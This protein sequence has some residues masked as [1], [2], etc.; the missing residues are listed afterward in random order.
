MNQQDSDYFKELSMLVGENYNKEVSTAK[1]RLWWQLLKDYPIGDIEQAIFNHMKESPFMPTPA[2][3]IKRMEPDYDLMFERCLRGKPET[4]L[5]KITWSA[6]SFACKTQLPEKEAR[7]RF[8]KEYKKQIEISK[9]PTAPATH[10]I[11]V[12][13]E[14]KAT[15]KMV[16]DGVDKY[17]GI[18][19]DE[20]LDMMRNFK[21][22][23]VP[24]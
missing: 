9:Q 22:K 18:S 15:D 13:K 6:V 17:K 14:V 4:K 3:L 10:R 5:E 23:K 19:R 1:L 8:K 21:L 20:A 24:K 12:Q 2:D 16:D 7:A 11:E